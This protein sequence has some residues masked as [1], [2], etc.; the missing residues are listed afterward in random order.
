MPDNTAGP[1]AQAR[2]SHHGGQGFLPVDLVPPRARGSVS[3]ARPLS[4][5]TRSSRRL[6]RVAPLLAALALALAAALNVASAAGRK[7]L[8][9]T[10]GTTRVLLGSGKAWRRLLPRHPMALKFVLKKRRFN[11]RPMTWRATSV[12]P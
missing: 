3:L 6:A 12:R 8:G 7:P 9:R 11:V 2:G 10:V 4:V 5:M 1:R